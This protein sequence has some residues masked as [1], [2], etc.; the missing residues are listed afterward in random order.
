MRAWEIKGIAAM[1]RAGVVGMVRCNALFL[2]TRPN[3]QGAHETPPPYHERTV[4]HEIA[5]RLPPTHERTNEA[6][7]A[8]VEVAMMTL[9]RS[10]RA[11]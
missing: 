8:G 1:P 9:P 7:R 11:A 2:Y 6:L 5:S 10:E 3:P 4:E